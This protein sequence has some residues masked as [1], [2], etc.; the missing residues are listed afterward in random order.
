MHWQYYFW[1]LFLLGVTIFGIRFFLNKTR[2]RPPE[3]PHD[4]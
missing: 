4:S 3:D 1:P 2:K